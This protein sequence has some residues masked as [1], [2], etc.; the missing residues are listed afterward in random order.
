MQSNPLQNRLKSLINQTTNFS[1]NS[2][3]I[4]RDIIDK[5]ILLVIYKHEASTID[6]ELPTY[7]YQSLHNVIGGFLSLYYIPHDR[8]EI[9]EKSLTNFDQSQINIDQSLLKFKYD[10][11]DMPITTLFYDN[12]FE[13]END[14]SVIPM[15]SSVQL[16]KYTPSANEFRRINRRNEQSNQIKEELTSLRN[17]DDGENN[18]DGFNKNSVPRRG[19][20]LHKRFDEKKRILNAKSAIDFIAYDLPKE[21]H[22]GIETLELSHLRNEA[23]GKEIHL[24]ETKRMSVINVIDQGSKKRGGVQSH[25]KQKEFEKKHYVVDAD[26]KIV[27]V[28]KVIL[29]RLP[30]EFSHVASEQKEKYVIN[31]QFQNQPIQQ[32]LLQ[33]SAPQSQLQG[34]SHPL[35]DTMSIP[36]RNSRQYSKSKVFHSIPVYNAVFPFSIGEMGHNSGSLEPAGSNFDLMKMEVGVELFE[37]SKYKTGG[38][39]FYR[40]Y[41]KYSINSFKE[42]NETYKYQHIDKFHPVIDTKSNNNDSFSSS[43]E[44]KAFKDDHQAINHNAKIQLR[45]NQNTNNFIQ[46]KNKNSIRNAFDKLDL[47][48][49]KEELKEDLSKEYKT[50]T[51]FFKPKRN[52]NFHSNSLTR[53]F[54]DKNKIDEMLKF[55][56]TIMSSKN[57]GNSTNKTSKKKS[58][59]RYPVK[60]QKN[61]INQE[62]GINIAK[63]KMPRSRMYSYIKPPFDNSILDKHTLERTSSTGFFKVIKKANTSKGSF[64]RTTSEKII[65]NNPKL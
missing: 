44:N 34:Q 62:I 32:Q 64:S 18:Q 45:N 6:N 30:P 13:R 42:H 40:K 9:I 20:Y 37:D 59:T 56:S 31:N 29:E 7:C 51:Y 63:V 2:E 17:S 65:E 22:Q 23:N 54:N 60:S 48:Y 58:H 1:C 10:D 12:Y 57:W 33:Q 24:K 25:P 39:D 3:T 49:E 4:S 50:S 36:N 26:R 5:L 8:D 55:N 35:V 47:I 21:K 14:W 43:S 11:N 61:I 41:H 52:N 27:E 16:D 19:T 28:K 15:P 53:N 38:K 46:V